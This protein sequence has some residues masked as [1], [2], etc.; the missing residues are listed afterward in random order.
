MFEQEIAT[1]DRLAKDYLEKIAKPMGDLEFRKHSEIIFSCHS[2]G[3]EG[4]SFSV[5]DTRAL[6]EQGLGYYPV[7][8]TLFECQEMADHFK[9]YEWM[10]DNLEH[11]FDVELMKTLNRLVTLNTLPYRVP[12]AVPGEFTTVDM[13]AGDTLFG[14]H[15]KLIEQLPRLME[16]TANAIAEGSIHPMVLAARFHGFFEYLHPFRDGNGRTGRLLSNFILLQYHLPELIICKEDRQEYINAL[17]AKRTE[18]TDEFLIAFFFKA[19][20]KQMQDEL[21]Q[22]HKGSRPMLFF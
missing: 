7:G 10:H 3:I 4:S 12:D 18:G 15:E 6:F 22:K 1:Y 13:A 16:S 8:K 21:D 20:I 14:D 17:K 19:A 5:D 9:A 11:P 2:C